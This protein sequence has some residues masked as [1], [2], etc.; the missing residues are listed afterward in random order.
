VSAPS[1]D[2][3]ALDL[4]EILDEAFVLLRLAVGRLLVFQLLIFV[5]TAAVEVGVISALGRAA[6][7]L[8]SDRA[9]VATVGP[10]AVVSIG[11]LAVIGIQLVVAPLAGV[12]LCRGVAD[13]YLGHRWGV[14]DLVR[15][16]LRYAGRA[17]VVALAV[18]LLLAVVVF[19]PL[20]LAGL[21]GFALVDGGAVSGP[22]ELALLAV[23]LGLL[24]LLPAIGGGVWV[25]LR[26]GLAPVALVVEE[27]GPRAALARSAALMRGRMWSGFGL[28]LVLTLIAVL[29]GALAS[30]LAPTPPIESLDPDQVRQLLPAFVDSQILSTVLSE[31]AGMITRTYGSI[32]WTLFYFSA[33]CRTE[34]FDL[35]RL[36]ERFGAPSP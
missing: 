17:V 15:V 18:S 32:A 8:V 34:G 35:L 9:D 21:I 14:G 3:R 27:L 24:G 1:F 29:L 11:A 16:A 31:A 26:Y 19:G 20:S 22:A 28:F 30:A 12:A 36:A 5:P 4:G 33:R 13:T 23:V 2:I 25:S 6:I 10:L 7:A